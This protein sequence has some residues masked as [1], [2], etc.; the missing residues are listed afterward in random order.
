MNNPDYSPCVRTFLAIN[1]MLIVPEAFLGFYVIAYKKSIASYYYYILAC[2]F[3]TLTYLF[4]KIKI[5]RLPSIF[6][7]FLFGILFNLS[8]Y[9]INLTDL[10]EVTPIFFFYAIICMGFLTGFNLSHSS[11]LFAQKILSPKLTVPIAWLLCV[12]YITNIYFVRQYNVRL[13]LGT[14]LFVLIPF[15][16][17]S[18]YYNTGILIWFF[19]FLGG[20][21]SVLLVTLCQ[22][23]FVSRE[24]FKRK[25][26]IA[27]L[28]ILTLPIFYLFQISGLYDRFFDEKYNLDLIANSNY[29]N[30]DTDIFNTYTSGRFA[31]ANVL[32]NHLMEDTKGLLFGFSA[33]YSFQV[34]YNNYYRDVRFFHVGYLNYIRC[35]GVVIGSFI[36]FH[37][38]YV[39]FR[40]FRAISLAKNPLICLYIG[41]F[42]SCLFGSANSSE[43]L[44]WFSYGYATGKLK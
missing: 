13:G 14:Q 33:D 25:K 32:I 23:I 26:F 37:N 1:I 41:S 22:L 27:L 11:N 30:F 17:C 21:R 9:K 20:K 18:P 44:F 43:V 4:Y 24:K 5:E 12:V 3:L 2:K 19:S 35:F 34:P 39:M 15:L 28:I 31:E 29:S 10:R 36:I 8:V 38:A 7:V 40:S 42:I 16:L 6:L